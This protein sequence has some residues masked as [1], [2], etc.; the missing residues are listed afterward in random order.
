MP[1][2]CHATLKR[3]R[4]S[5]L[6]SPPPKPCRLRPE[7]AVEIKCHKEERQ[8]PKESKLTDSEEYAAWSGRGRSPFKFP[9]TAVCDDIKHNARLAEYF[10]REIARYRSELDEFNAAKGKELE[11]IKQRAAKMPKRPNNMIA[12]APDLRPA[13]SSRARSLSPD[14]YLSKLASCVPPVFKHT[15]HELGNKLPQQ[16][17]DLVLLLTRGLE[18]SCIPSRYKDA[19]LHSEFDVPV[20]AFG[21]IP[22]R[23]KESTELLCKTAKSIREQAQICEAECRDENAWS[24][25]VVR[26]VMEWESIGQSHAVAEPGFS[27]TE[28]IQTQ[29]INTSY[30]PR[31]DGVPIESKKADFAL[32]FSPQHPDVKSHY[33]ALQVPGSEPSTLS[34][35]NDVCTRKLALYLAAEVKKFGGNEM[36]AEAQLFTWLAAGVTKSRKLLKKAKFASSDTLPLLGWTIV[37][38][39]WELYMALGKGIEEASEINIFGPFRTCAV[40][41]R[42]YFSVFKLLRINERIKLWAR[43]QYW[44]WFCEAVLDPLKGLPKTPEEMDEDEEDDE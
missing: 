28:Y 21:D 26:P 42:T 41:T 33:T 5:Q 31:I 29:T 7:I 39:R 36:E 30:L 13:L 19:V 27:R 1:A 25:N 14:K 2:N 22:C 12:N 4:S 18:D 37:G 10:F 32:S 34:Q 16:I 24:M 43:E 23:P 9:V 8:L 11:A 35:L 38:H 20:H 40:D 6:S 3:K 15:S 17:K 44:P